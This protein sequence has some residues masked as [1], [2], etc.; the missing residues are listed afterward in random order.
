MRGLDRRLYDGADPTRDASG[1]SLVR[2]L[3]VAMQKR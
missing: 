1:G 3:L 2:I